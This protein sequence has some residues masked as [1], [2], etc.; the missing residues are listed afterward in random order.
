MRGGFR[1]PRYDGDPFAKAKQDAVKT[2]PDSEDVVD[3]DTKPIDL[4]DALKASVEKEA[5]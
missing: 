4:I 5:E 3:D 1:Q 2:V